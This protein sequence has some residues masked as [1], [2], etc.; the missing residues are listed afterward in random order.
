MRICDRLITYNQ[1][2]FIKDRYILVSVVAAHDII[3]E[4]AKK[5]EPGI[6]L[7]IDYGKSYDRVTWSFLEEVLNSRGF[8]E[9]WV[10]WI[11]LLTRGGS[12]CVRMNDINISYFGVGKGLRQGDPLS[13]SLSPF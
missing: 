7:K 11:K 3:H 9:K 1:S 10:N 13:L 6:I 8:S 12:V 2:A 5:G 4:I